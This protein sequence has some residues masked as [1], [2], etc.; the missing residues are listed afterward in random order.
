MQS[1]GYENVVLADNGNEAVEK[2]SKQHF[3][4]I[5]M[6]LMVYDGVG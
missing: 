1:I 2:A 6:D 3:N 4:V 5:F